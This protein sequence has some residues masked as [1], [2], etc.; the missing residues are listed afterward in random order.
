MR[1][2]TFDSIAVDCPDMKLVCIHTGYPWERELVA[3][4]RKHENLYIGADNC[5]PRAWSAELVDYIRYDLSRA[6]ICCDDRGPGAARL[7]AGDTRTARARQRLAGL[8]PVTAR[9]TDL[10]RQS[11]SG[12]C[13]RLRQRLRR[14]P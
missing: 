1:P 10:P 5:R 14:S 12:M 11:A 3:H 2:Q 8:R 7:R 9:G 4:D 6:G 13:R